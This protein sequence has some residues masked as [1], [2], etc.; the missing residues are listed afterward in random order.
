MNWSSRA[1]YSAS[2]TSSGLSSFAPFFPFFAC[3]F[4]S[5]ASAASFAAAASSSSRRA[6][7]SRDAPAGY[8]RHRRPLPLYPQRRHGRER[9]RRPTRDRRGPR[10]GG[11]LFPL[12]LP[13][14]LELLALA[15]PPFS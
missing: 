9:R 12:L 2:M 5:A 14:P 4:T 15:R 7:S 13:S 11:L 6:S 1:R 3:A 8:E 10:R